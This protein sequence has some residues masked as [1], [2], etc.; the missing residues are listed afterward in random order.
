MASWTDDIGSILQFWPETPLPKLAQLMNDV[1]SLLHKTDI[2]FTVSVFAEGISKELREECEREFASLS[3]RVTLLAVAPAPTVQVLF[4]V[5]FEDDS[6]IFADAEQFR[7]SFDKQDYEKPLATCYVVPQTLPAYAV[8]LYVSGREEEE[9]EKVIMDYV[10]AVSNLSWLS[11]KPG[12]EK[13]T[14]SY[15]PHMVALMRKMSLPTIFISRYEFLPSVE[16][17]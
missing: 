6:V 2:E 3:G 4:P 5:A 9:P 8:S 10:T 14:I 17:M 7:Q 1:V 16:K 13:R 11:V 15:P 12:S